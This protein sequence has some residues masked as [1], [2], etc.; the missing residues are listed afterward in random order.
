MK[1]GKTIELFAWYA[2]I[3][4]QRNMSYRADFIVGLI[5]S[6]CN[7]AIGPLFQ[8]LLFT[9]TK[10]YPG[11]SLYQVMLFQGMLLLFTGIRG[12]LFGNVFGNVS[13]M[14]WRGDFDRLLILPRRPITLLLC[15][16]F[17]AGSVG[18][19]LSGIVLLVYS[20]NVLEIVVNPIRLVLV[21]LGLTCGLML[22]CAFL[23]GYCILLVMVTRNSRVE[24]VIMAM[25][26][27]AGYPAQIFPKAIGTVLSTVLPFLVVAY[28][29]SQVLL[30]RADAAVVPGMF[31]CFFALMATLFIWERMLKRYTSVGG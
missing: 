14:V 17:D 30:G 10:G 16:G 25:F 4:L 5:I 20:A 28:F 26:N 11:W 31:V 3:R 18:V 7:A 12:M 24:E 23:V 19:L 22:Y 8:F 29:P 13:T 9:T 27:F 21:L 1:I 6:V 15:S 2:R